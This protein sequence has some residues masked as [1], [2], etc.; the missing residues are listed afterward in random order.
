MKKLIDFIK[1]LFG[2]SARK[3][4][5]SKDLFILGGYDARLSRDMDEREGGKIENLAC[6]HF[7]IVGPYNPY[8]PSDETP[9]G[10]LADWMVE[11]AEECRE[12][13]LCLS[14]TIVPTKDD[15]DNH[16][17]GES[18]LDDADDDDFEKWINDEDF[19][20]QRALDN[21]GL[22]DRIAIHD[23]ILRAPYFKG[24]KKLS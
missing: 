17:I 21:P 18:D 23:W 8:C 6:D 15:D 7:T 2:I 16:P 3:C 22:N 20:V 5:S 9:C 14:Y 11:H 1:R 12:N 10:W 4:H 19:Q 13:N 24:R